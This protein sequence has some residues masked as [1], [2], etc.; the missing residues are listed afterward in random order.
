MHDY[1]HSAATVEPPAVIIARLHQEMAATSPD[2]AVLVARYHQVRAGKVGVAAAAAEA[3]KAYMPANSAWRA[4]RIEEFCALRDRKVSVA[5][6]AA[7]VGVGLR[8]GT[9]YN[10]IWRRR[11]SDA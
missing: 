10:L 4:R 3:A 5:D 11:A 6:A 2:L 7:A 8:T 1:Q 9:E